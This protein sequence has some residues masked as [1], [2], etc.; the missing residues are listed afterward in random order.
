MVK[1]TYHLP[2]CTLM[3]LL[4][5]NVWWFDGMELI[6][7]GFTYV[8]ALELYRNGIQCVDDIRDNEHRTFL[9]WDE[10]QIKFI[11]TNADNED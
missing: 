3:E 8:G 6:V 9:S 10:A 11:L 4:H 5:S 7:N 2:P 1:G